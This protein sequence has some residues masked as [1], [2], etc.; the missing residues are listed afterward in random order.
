[1]KWL[2]LTLQ[3]FYFP[4]MVVIF[5]GSEIV[6]AENGLGFHYT[7]LLMAL[8]LFVSFS[9]E[10]IIPH[11]PSWN[12]SKGD[13]KRDIYHFWFNEVMIYASIFTLPFL[14][15]FALFPEVWPTHWSFTFQLILAVVIL[16][17][18]STLFH[19]LCHKNSFLW[20]FHAVH[21]APTRLY[22]LNGIMKH[23]VFQAIDGV[24]ALAPL[25]II[26][27]PQNVAFALVFSIFT[28]L[29]IQH[30]NADIKT[31]WFRALFATAELHR[32]HHLKGRAGDV[33]FALF[34][35]IWDRLLGTAFFQHRKPLA[36]D[37]I[38]IG[39]TDYPNDYWSQIKKTFESKRQPTDSA[40]LR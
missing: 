20:R 36:D 31:G 2:K 38:G 28:Q 26:G 1:M 19:Y 22:G 4:V 8:A 40:E 18:G 34:F 25:I 21:H 30:T 14:S 15:M 23:P 33:N 39:N 32:F 24:F 10:R 35:S 16:D 13:L 3:L 6:I 12:K 29:L 7:L 17:I 37:E 11:K 27:I 9:V 5:I